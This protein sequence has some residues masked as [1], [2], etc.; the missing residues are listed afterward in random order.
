MCVDVCVYSCVNMYVC[1]H[2]ACEHMY[3]CETVSMWC[4]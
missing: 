1:E 2:C 4:V 3:E